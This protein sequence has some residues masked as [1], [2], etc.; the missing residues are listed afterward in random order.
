MNAMLPC[1]CSDRACSAGSN[2]ASHRSNAA[3]LSLQVA[4]R[5]LQSCT[6]TATSLLIT[7]LKRV[8]GYKKKAAPYVQC[9]HTI[10]HPACHAPKLDADKPEW[11]QSH[12][13]V[14]DALVVGQGARGHE[15][16]EVVG[17][18][19]RA[20]AHH[21]E[22]GLGSAQFPGDPAG[23]ARWPC[24]PLLALALACITILNFP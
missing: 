21:L 8:R 15:G 14:D 2:L 10:T 11:T 17:K 9:M 6:A 3:N 12:L 13:Q 22:Q 16:E 19:V 7:T 23:E 4:S 24:L 18:G 20:A 1:K 5:S